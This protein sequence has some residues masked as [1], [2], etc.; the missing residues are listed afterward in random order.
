MT[1]RIFRAIVLTAML[2]IL[3]TAVLI[4]SMVFR[5]FSDQSSR[6]MRIEARTIASTLTFVP[7]D[8]AYLASL[9]NAH[10]ITL[11]K[12]DGTVLFDNSADEADMENHA[13]RPEILSALESGEGASQRH[14][15]TLSKQTSY[16]AIRTQEGTVLRLASTQSS[17]LG[18][19]L[20][21]L[22]LLVLVMGL[23]TLLALQI[24]RIIAGHI[25]APVNTLDLDRPLSNSVYDELSPLLTRMDRQNEQIRRQVRD[26]ERAHSEMAAVINSMREGLVLLDKN[27]A[28][29]SINDS[30]ADVLSLHAAD[31]IGK[32]ALSLIAEEDLCSALAA[33]MRGQRA[34]GMLE[35][36]GRYIHAYANP[37]KRMGANKGAV[38]LLVDVTEGYTAEVIRRE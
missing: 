32:D 4:V 16:Y 24:A 14:S 20:N 26:L 38:L 6:D 18:L 33:A 3:L 7:E 28:V 13:Q 15:D 37:V 17:L 27:R 11:V 30:A 19:Y 35:R 25:V 21:V 34:E 8:A 12:A 5:F 29:L 22:P 31:C 2:A 10:R 9:D 36:G 1:R 23:V